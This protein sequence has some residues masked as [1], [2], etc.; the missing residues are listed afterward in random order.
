MGAMASI[1]VVKTETDL[2]A[3]GKTNMAGHVSK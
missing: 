3:K 1:Y 2:T